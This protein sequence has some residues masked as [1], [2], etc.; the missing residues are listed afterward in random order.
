MA[1]GVFDSGVGGLTVYKELAAA[2]PDTDLIYLGDTARVP[3]GN[4]SPETI[5]SYAKDCARYLVDNY[6]VSSLIVACNTITCHAIEPLETEFGIPALGVIEAGAKQ[7]LAVSQNKKIGVIATRATVNSC[8]YVDMLNKLSGNTV[9]VYQQAC[10]LLVPLVEEGILTGPVP[11]E[12]V[13]M[14]MNEMVSEGIDT[15]ILA[16]T[17]FP[18]L[19]N[20]ISKLY[21][22]LRLADS[23]TMMVTQ[24][25]ERNM[26]GKESGKREVLVTAAS[27]AFEKL[28]T[29]MVGD[30]PLRVVKLNTES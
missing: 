29:M 19:A 30:V 24:M 25:Q 1:I 5:V 22:S 15:V 3:Y 9:K 23:A 17:H 20:V 27:D 7:A 8:A 4:K 21:M 12:M 11:E 10:P 16:C 13:K 2:F 26:A 6:H 18:L 28:K 14:Y